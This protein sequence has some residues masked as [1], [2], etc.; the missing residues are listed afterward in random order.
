MRNYKNMFSLLIS[1]LTLRQK[2]K[3]LICI[4]LFLEII[5]IE[6]HFPTSTD[7]NYQKYL[8]VGPMTR[9]A[10]DLDLMMKAISPDY[11]KQLEKS[12]NILE[13]Q[14]F[15][16]EEFEKSNAF[17]RVRPEIKGAIR[18]SAEFLRKAG[19]S[20]SDLKFDFKSAFEMSVSI[21]FNMKDIPYALKY[22]RPKQVDSLWLELTKSI[23]GQSIYT[24]NLLF[25]YFIE[26]MNAFVPKRRYEFY[27]YIK[28]IMENTLMEKLG[29]NGVLLC[30]TFPVPAFEHRTSVLNL[31]NVTYCMV[32]N[33]LGMP[34]THVPIGIDRDGLPYG[35]QVNLNKKLV[36][37]IIPYP[38]HYLLLPMSENMVYISIFFV[39]KYG[40]HL[41]K[42]HFSLQIHKNKCSIRK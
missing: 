22:N 32:F 34:C 40:I 36:I 15:T 10:E 41:R 19:C 12:L 20:R 35:I 18:S 13:I 5:S 29:N 28:K 39:R 4:L 33:I 27:T 3:I 38:P 6:G 30:P 31:S 23:F 37:F 7:P 11:C 17:S 25:F 14:I 2:Y 1:H 8:T 9:Y 26:K 24:F 16:C 42:N 21:F